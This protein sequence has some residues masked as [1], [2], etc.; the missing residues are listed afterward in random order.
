MTTG[1]TPTSETESG[2]QF[3]LAASANTMEATLGRFLDAARVE[4]VYGKPVQ[5]D[6][7]IVI[8]SA[9]VLSVLGVGL[10]HGGGVRAGGGGGGGG[11]RVLARPVAA[12]VISP[13]GVRVEPII[14]TTKIA[15][16][17][18]TAAGFMIG[19]LIRMNRLH[20]RPR[21]LGDNS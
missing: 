8:P 20:R 4:A 1:S 3:D 17:A 12:V 21:A 13:N 18:L 7:T 9:E 2:R 10:G 6:A 15:L 5:N 16:A 14:D 11:G 19:M